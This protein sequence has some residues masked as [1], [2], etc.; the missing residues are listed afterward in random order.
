ML[1]A[2]NSCSHQTAQVKWQEKKEYIWSRATQTRSVH[3]VA[4]VANTYH[5]ISGLA[6]KVEYI[7]ELVHSGG[8]FGATTVQQ[9]CN[10]TTVMQDS[11]I[12]SSECSSAYDTSH[13]P[14]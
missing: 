3:G 13:D 7:V 10:D 9:V 6:G 11:P 4:I 2:V 8:V 1:V 14:V 5:A 12:A